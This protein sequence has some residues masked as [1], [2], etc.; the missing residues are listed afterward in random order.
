M[1][2]N[3]ASLGTCDLRVQRKNQ[4]LPSWVTVSSLLEMAF[5]FTEPSPLRCALAGPCRIDPR[6]RSERPGSFRRSP[7]SWESLVG[8][9]VGGRGGGRCGHWG[10][11]SS[12]RS[13]GIARFT[14]IFTQSCTRCP[15]ALRR[16][17]PPLQSSGRYPSD[18][19]TKG[20]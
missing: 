17:P 20:S 16:K 13:D 9:R 7:Q 14:A 12:R 19:V 8:G 10:L 3:T 18:D 2:R 11:M 15:P 1:Q 6:T 4:S 5:G